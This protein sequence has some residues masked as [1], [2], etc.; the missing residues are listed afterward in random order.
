MDI[1][2]FCTLSKQCESIVFFFASF[3]NYKV[4]ISNS[5]NFFPTLLHVI[6]LLFF[7]AKAVFMVTIV[8]VIMLD[9]IVC[10]QVV[11]WVWARATDS[12]SHVKIQSQFSRVCFL[13]VFYSR[14]TEMQPILR[15]KRNKS[16][17]W[18]T[19][20]IKLYTFSTRISPLNKRS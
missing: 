5:M 13:F 18:N 1:D 9:W 20:K 11:W 3:R 8:V 14:L 2:S 17:D 19:I 16:R 4:S 15:N 12:L 6:T 7:L 10:A